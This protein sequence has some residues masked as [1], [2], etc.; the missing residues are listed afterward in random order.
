MQIVGSGA[1]DYGGGGSGGAAVFG[2]GGLSEDAKL[3]DGVDGDLNS[4]VSQKTKV[5]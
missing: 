1:R 3:G 4:T 5:C 2:R